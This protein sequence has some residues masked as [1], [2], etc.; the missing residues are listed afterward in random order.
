[1]ASAPTDRS[2]PAL[3]GALSLDLDHCHETGTTRLGNAYRTG[4]FH[5]GKPYWDGGQLVVQVLNPTAGI[6]GGDRMESTFRIGPG[7]RGCIISPSSN[8]VYSMPD[9]G[10]GYANQS[11]VVE[12]GGALSFLPKWLV[13]HKGSRFRQETTLQLSRDSTLFYVDFLSA[14]RSSFGEFLD[15]EQ[16]LSRTEFW[17][18]GRLFLKERI[19]SGRQRNRWIWESGGSQF[20]YLANVYLHF[21][22]A[23]AFCEEA[24][25][26][27]ADSPFPDGAFGYTA[28]SD[29]F[30]SIRILG[31]SS[32]LVEAFVS[33]VTGKLPPSVPASAVLKRIR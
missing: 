20:G 6:F 25:S 29:N 32:R 22:K 1:M 28:L 30:V 26:A 12:G 31:P 8:Q 23:A 7:A 19:F 21:P 13:L 11:I 33:Q 27:F 24:F 5:F 17:I 3:K 14:G 18:D 9:G 2:P 15:F 10:T 4:L 16:F